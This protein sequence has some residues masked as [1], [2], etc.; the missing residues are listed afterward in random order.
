MLLY[1]FTSDAMSRR[2]RS[3]NKTVLQARALPWVTQRAGWDRVLLKALQMGNSS[4]TSWFC[5]AVKQSRSTHFITTTQVRFEVAL[6]ELIPRS[7]KKDLSCG[8]HTLNYYHRSFPRLSFTCTESIKCLWP[9]APEVTCRLLFVPPSCQM[10]LSAFL[11]PCIYV[12][13][14]VKQKCSERCWPWPLT[15]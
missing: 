3:K 7:T 4:K 1:L 9:R 2:C 10:P 12:T 15:P 13:Q 8:R 14:V 11:I 6:A 5:L